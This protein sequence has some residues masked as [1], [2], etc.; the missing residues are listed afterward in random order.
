MPADGKRHPPPPRPGPLRPEEVFSFRALWEAA[1]RTARG[2]RRRPAMARFRLEMED[3][4]LRLQRELLD[5]SWQP[6]PGQSLAIRDPKPRVITVPSV[7]DRVV[8]QAIMLVL[9]P[10]IERRLI[11]DTYACRVGY[12]THA[13]LRRAAA[14]ARTYRWY[15]HLDVERFFPSID[16]AIVR[17]H[18]AQD[19]PE[20]WLRAL[21][22]RILDG[23]HAPA[24]RAFFPG[25]DLFTPTSRA[26]G[27]PLGSL[28]SQWWANR[29]LD[30]IDHH[31]KDRL[32]VRPYL[33]YMD[34]LVLFAD[35][36]EALA[37]L[38]REVEE[39]MWS[40]RLR[41]HRY[42]VMPTSG[43]LGF[44]GYRVQPDQT[45]V[46]RTT[47]A[48]AERRLA[49]HLDMLRRGELRREDFGASLRSTLAHWR[50]ADSF[51]LKERFFRRLGLLHEGGVRAS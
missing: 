3:E 4:L 42:E 14:W 10:R 28:T 5:G 20:P 38:V 49:G 30:P 6:D 23:A 9:G 15:V 24:H 31:I 12:G 21:C 35:D 39:R 44:V 1:A 40:L 26:A 13:A 7:R 2:K 18:L 37:R 47:V 36:R 16:H 46:K 25:D 45:R 29:Y 43:G 48:R 41:L 27:L 51:R 19:V 17:Q 32:R 22:E 33:R 11:R 34:D 8:H 50:F